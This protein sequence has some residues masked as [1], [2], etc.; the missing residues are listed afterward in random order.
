MKSKLIS[1]T[2]TVFLLLGALPHHSSA[3]HESSDHHEL[4]QNPNVDLGALTKEIMIMEFKNGNTHLAMWMTFDFFVAATTSQGKATK[5]E[6]EK[7]LEFLKP[8]LTMVVQSSSTQADGTSVYANE[9]EVRARAALKL[10]DGSEVYPLEK[11]PPIVSA[12]MAAMKSAIAAEGDAGSA[13]MHILVFPAISKQGQKIVDTARKDKLTLVLRADKKFKET[14]FTWRT[15]FDALTS[16]SD[17][18]RCKA[19]LSVKWTYCPY[20]GHKI[21]E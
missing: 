4:A 19:G 12:T 2:A 17:C 14:S 18:P 15:P 20:C 13:N 21:P 5:A 6:A 11:P 9:N 7:T 1:C 8:Y 3:H 16:V 10:P